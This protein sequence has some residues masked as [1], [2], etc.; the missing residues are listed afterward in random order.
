MRHPPAAW[1]HRVLWRER[2]VAVVSEDDPLAEQDSLAIADLLERALIGIPAG[3]GDEGGGFDLRAALGPAAARA[4]IA[5]LADQPRALVALVRF[6][7]GVG[8]IRHCALANVETGGVTVRAIDSP[9]AFHDMAVFWTQRRAQDASIAAFLDAQ[10]H[11]P[12]PPTCTRLAGEPRRRHGENFA[13][14]GL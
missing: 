6:G 5:H 8:V 1:F 7:F 10:R 12:L 14:S 13:D 4:E 9:T 2:V 11:A 3:A